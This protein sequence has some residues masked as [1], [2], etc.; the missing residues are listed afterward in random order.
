MHPARAIAA[1]V[2]LE[3][4][5]HDCSNTRVL[6]TEF[7]PSPMIEV[8]AAWKFELRKKVGQRMRGSQGIN[9]LGLL[10]IRQEL[11]IDAQ[12]FFCKR[13]S[14]AALTQAV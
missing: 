14:T 7:K 13:G 4:F 3:D 10:P 2:A 8:G 5:G 9:Q 12:L 11:L 1:V 6:V